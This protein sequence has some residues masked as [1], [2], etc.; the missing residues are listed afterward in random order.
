MY[1]CVVVG[2]RTVGLRRWMGCSSRGRRRRR[3]T[4]KSLAV[5][6]VVLVSATEEAVV[7]ILVMIV[8]VVVVVVVLVVLVAMRTGRVSLA[9]VKHSR[10]CGLK[11]P[12]SRQKREIQHGRNWSLSR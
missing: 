9:T 5:V 6:L 4:G 12:R 10:G 2:S 7:M 11:D 8:V 1:V 3:K